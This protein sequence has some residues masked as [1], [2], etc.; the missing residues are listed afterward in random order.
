MQHI[1]P[2]IASL[3]QYIA[4]RNNQT[5]RFRLE[6][7]LNCGHAYPWFHGCYFRKADRSNTT[8]E[9][10]N[11]IPIQRFYCP[12]CRRTSSALPECIPARRWYLW[13]FQQIVLM[14]ALMDHRPQDAIKK[15]IAPSRQTISRWLTRFR[16][17]FHRHKDALLTHASHLGRTNGFSEFWPC[18]FASMLLSSAMRI[19]HVSG[20]PVP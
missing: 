17:Q 11:P 6:Q 2:E 10:L 19:C 20:V 7:C 9:S 14:L 4:T 1:I 5:E 13:E 15:N 12:E 3:V 8:Q 18:C 16:E